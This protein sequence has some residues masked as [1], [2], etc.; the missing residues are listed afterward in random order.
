MSTTFERGRISAICIPD[1][2]VKC[3]PSI[4][5]IYIFLNIKNSIFL[6]KFWF[7]RS[8]LANILVLRSPF[9]KILVLKYQNMSKNLFLKIKISR[10]FGFL[11]RIAV[12]R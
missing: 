10:N 2:F 4:L 12:F 7:F 8:K 5:I 6:S 11:V 9:I 1:S 3:N